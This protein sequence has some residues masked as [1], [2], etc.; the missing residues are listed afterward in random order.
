MN[1]VCQLSITLSLLR[2]GV[3][4]NVAALPWFRSLPKHCFVYSW[5]S[6]VFYLSTY[7]IVLTKAKYFKYRWLSLCVPICPYMSRMSRPWHSREHNAFVSKHIFCK[8]EQR[9]IQSGGGGIQPA[10]EIIIW[11]LTELHSERNKLK[12]IY[13]Q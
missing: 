4:L 7:P 8:R 11:V 13:K 6:S 9:K 1:G 12:N 10:V 5:S 2:K 3:S